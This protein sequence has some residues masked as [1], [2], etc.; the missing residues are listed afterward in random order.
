[1]EIITTTS[2]EFNNTRK[3]F[4]NHI[5]KVI[6]DD[7]LIH[8]YA[9]PEG[10]SWPTF[11][12]TK[13]RRAKDTN[14]FLHRFS[15]T[16]EL[17][18]HETVKLLRKDEIIVNTGLA[19]IGKSIEF[20]AYLMKFLN[21]I[22]NEGWPNKVWYR[23]DNKL[24][25]FS[26]VN[27]QTN[28]EVVKDATIFNVITLTRVGYNVPLE[29]KPIL[30]MDMLEHETNPVSYIGTL[31]QPHNLDVYEL[32][33]TFSKSKTIYMLIDT[34]TLEEMITMAIMYVK[35]G[36]SKMMFGKYNL[37]DDEI[38]IIVTERVE[39]LGPVPWTIFDDDDLFENKVGSTIYIANRFA[40]IIPSI[41]LLR[42][43]YGIE[44]I[45]TP[46][47]KDK[48][49]YPCIIGSQKHVEFGIKFL[50]SFLLYAAMET[51]TSK[52]KINKMIDYNYKY[53]FEIQKA[54]VIYGLT[55]KSHLDK[56]IFKKLNISEY[57]EILS[58]NN[59]NWLIKNWIFYNNNKTPKKI[60][61]TDTN[62]NICDKKRYFDSK[63]LETD[64]RYLDSN[65]LYIP[66]INYKDL[67]D[68]LYVDQIN[69]ILYIFQSNMHME[70]R[71]PS[72]HIIKLSTLYNTLKYLNYFEVQDNGNYNYTIR[73]IY[74]I[75]FDTILKK[76]CKLEN[77]IT[78]ID[79]KD[80]FQIIADS[81][82]IF[83][84]KIKLFNLN[85]IY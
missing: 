30:L 50:S 22:G 78:N 64:I 12:A 25:K 58:E 7:K 42:F 84:A 37:S 35:Y 61:L 13:Q 3:Q 57:A 49:A 47:V 40:N 26:L 29:D 24:L 76:S 43:P 23:Y 14:I 20:N 41:S 67:Y 51:C 17:R 34:P 73:Y 46:F 16:H 6:S 70:L 31:I 36:S 68:C 63:Y 10:K 60:L 54:I 19:G 1:L 53:D 38:R 85:E 62:I 66:S 4:P 8:M 28:V 74:C 72:E 75:P 27:G 44:K 69:R 82:K 81:M 48:T 79:N 2:T 9:L 5:I 80:K 59:S 45:V 18:F 77:D 15:T 11:L 83:I 52:D 32:T 71:Q 56:T 21:N 65:T 33:R 55:I 39:I